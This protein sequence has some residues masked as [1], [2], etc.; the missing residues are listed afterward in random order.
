MNQSAERIDK[1][2]FGP[3]AIVT[4]ASSGIGKEFSRQLAANGAK[5]TIRPF[6]TFPVK[7]SI[8]PNV[9]FYPDR[10]DEIA[11]QLPTKRESLQHSRLAFFH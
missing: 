6:N 7:T 3:W 10:V 2:K 11:E 9:A 1:F 4:G 8:S 5:R